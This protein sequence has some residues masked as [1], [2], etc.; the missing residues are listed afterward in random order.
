M[1][2]SNLHFEHWEYDTV[3]FR[4]YFKELLATWKSRKVSIIRKTDSALTNM[5]PPRASMTVTVLAV[6][7]VLIFFM[8]SD[9]L[10]VCAATC[11]QAW[12]TSTGPST[13]KRRV[14]ET[15]PVFTYLRT[16]ASEMFPGTQVVNKWKGQMSKRTEWMEAVGDSDRGWG[17][18]ERP[19]MSIRPAP[20]FYLSYQNINPWVG[21][22]HLEPELGIRIEK[23]TQLGVGWGGESCS[24][25]LG[26]AG[27][28]IGNKWVGEWA[29]LRTFGKP[30]ICSIWRDKI[31]LDQS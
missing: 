12:T 13:D 31:Y 16:S 26:L 7:L 15:D 21:R 6:I 19:A 10:N 9:S 30:Q 1:E 20:V 17:A 28:S 24:S 23:K 22:A 2:L 27:E 29:F 8:P 25:F 3:F 4:H 11:P 5:P 14:K 18:G